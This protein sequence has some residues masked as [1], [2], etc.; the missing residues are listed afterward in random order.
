MNEVYNYEIIK[1]KI[2]RN[3]NIVLMKKDDK[4]F[5]NYVAALFDNAYKLYK[6][7]NFISCSKDL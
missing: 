1:E 2:D 6:N 3:F 5:S 4:N 7:K